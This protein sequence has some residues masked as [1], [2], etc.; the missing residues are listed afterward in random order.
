[1]I[2][3]P[4]AGESRR[5]ISA[6][7]KLPKYMLELHG[8]T[9]FD[10][11]VE[12]F[13]SYMQDELFVFV[14]RDIDG[15][16]DFVTSRVEA[17]GVAHARYVV[18]EHPTAG[19]AET[20]AYG[21]DAVPAHADEPLMIFNIDTIRPGLARTPWAS[22]KCDGWLE[23]FSGDGD[24]WS[25]VLP[26]AKTDIVTRT[27]EKIRISN[28]CCTGLYEFSHV[29]LFREAFHVECAN[30]SAKELYVAPVYNHLIAAGRTIRFRQIEPTD[31]IFSGVPSEYEAL[32]A[33]P[34]PL[35]K[36]DHQ[37]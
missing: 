18:L 17:L 23:V 21:L 26:T 19:Q 29:S 20:V 5:F 24:G 32:L 9:L 8:R 16:F 10:W 35:R 25:F 14:M 4:M 15:T 22:R 30:R 11:S 3:I 33:D 6:G 28:L 31:V 27:A 13:R 2:I 37:F 12:S 1:M 34:S 36:F 7:Y